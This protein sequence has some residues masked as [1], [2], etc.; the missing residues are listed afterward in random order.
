[1]TGNRPFRHTERDRK[2]DLKKI[3]ITA[4]ALAVLDGAAWFGISR[5]EDSRYET[6]GGESNVYVEPVITEARTVEVDGV[7]YVQKPNI[8]TYLLMGID[9]LG[10]ATDD[11]GKKG[12]FA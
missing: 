1:M 5:W 11:D 7:T 6:E 3:G 2:K 12:R 4:C 10:I 8:E 9:E